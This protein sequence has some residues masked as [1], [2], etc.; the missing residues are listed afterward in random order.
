M[1]IMKS[2]RRASVVSVRRAGE[3]D[4]RGADRSADVVIAHRVA[5]DMN[6]ARVAK[7]SGGR[8]AG[9]QKNRRTLATRAT[10]ATK[11]AEARRGEP[12]GQRSRRARKRSPRR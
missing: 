3:A 9:A 10:G 7:V 12:S 4:A 1:R 6:S 11:K 5:R 2:K 8:V